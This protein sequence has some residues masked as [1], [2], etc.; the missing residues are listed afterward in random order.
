MPPHVAECREQ[1][2]EPHARAQL[3]RGDAPA[4]IHREEKREW[5]LEVADAAV[6]QPRGMRRRSRPKISLID[7]RR[8]EP[9]RRG[10]ARDPRPRDAA[11]NDEDI[12]GRLDHGGQGCRS[13]LLQLPSTWGWW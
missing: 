7:Q 13:R 6:D 9:A 8:A 1:V 2:V 12:H 3:P 10:I 5:Q 11:A 4:T